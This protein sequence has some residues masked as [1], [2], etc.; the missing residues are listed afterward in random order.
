VLVQ[1]WPTDGRPHVDSN[2]IEYV[3]QP[4]PPSAFDQ[5]RGELN[6]KLQS[7]GEPE[8]LLWEMIGSRL[9]TGPMFAKY[10]TVLRGLGAGKHAVDTHMV[11]QFTALC[12]GNM[13]PTTLH[14]INSSIIK[15]SKVCRPNNRMSSAPTP[16][17]AL[18]GGL[19]EGPTRGQWT[20]THRRRRRQ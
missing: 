9:Y 11:S 16:L 19:V 12:K 13:Y 14:V 6:A 15:L 3:R 7:M 5:K 17:R 2:G 20:M 18:S 10:N 1:G 4:L 8:L